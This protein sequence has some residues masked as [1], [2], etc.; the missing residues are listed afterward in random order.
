[1][2]G[3]AK[4]QMRSECAQNAK[5][6][7]GTENGKASLRQTVFVCKECGGNFTTKK[8]CKSR[9]P[10]YCGWDCYMKSVTKYTGMTFTCEYCGIDFKTDKA[11]R[12]RI[13]KYCSSKCYGYATRGR[14]A[15]N[16]GKALSK[17]HKEALSIGRK[18]S[19]KCKGPNLYNWRGGA[20]TFH[21]R[22]RVYQRQPVEDAQGC[23]LL[24]WTTFNS[25]PMPRTPDPTFTRRKQSALQFSLCL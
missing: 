8:A 21:E 9:V 13:P 15:W 4:T 24:L 5:V 17:E 18:N 12:G 10:V 23:M 7:T 14:P 1:M 2:N 11:Y 20:A 3:Q 19:Q 16:R 6:P 22:T 25:L